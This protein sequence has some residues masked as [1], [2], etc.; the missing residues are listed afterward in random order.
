[1]G[2]KSSRIAP[3][4]AELKEQVV[5]LQKTV[6]ELQARNKPRDFVCSQ[7]NILA[8]YLGDNRQ[9]WFLYGI[10]CPPERREQIMTKF[11]QRG[12]DGRYVN[13]GWPKY[14][15]GI[16]TDAEMA[17]VE[18]IDEQHFAWSSRRPRVRDEILALDADLISLVELDD[19]EEY[20]KPEL[21]ARGY[22]SVFKKRPRDSSKDGCGIFFRTSAFELLASDSIEFVDRED[23]VTKKKQKDR[24]GLLAYLKH[25]SGRKV[26]FISTH[27]ARNP[28]DPKQTKSRAK[29]A[30]QLLQMLTDFAL[31]HDAMEVPV[32]LAGDMNTTSIKQIANI[33]RSVFELCE[34]P[35]HPFVF[36]AFAPR[37]LPTSV[38]TTRKM[39]IDYML[40]GRLDVIDLIPLPKLTYDAPIPNAEHPSDHVPL[41]FRF[42]FSKMSSHIATAARGYI[43]TLL[44]DANSAGA[45]PLNAAGL[46]DAFDFFDMEQ[47]GQCALRELEAALLDLQLMDKLPA[48]RSAIEAE[49]GHSLDEEASGGKALQFDE[50]SK[51]YRAAFL[52]ARAHFKKDMQDAFQYFDSDGS[53]QLEQKE[54]YSS[55]SAAC[56][57]HISEETF[58]GIFAKL[59]ANSDGTVT[60]DEFVDF[61]MNR[62]VT[63]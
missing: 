38:T 34:R 33:A 44:G 18:K 47:D 24:V 16:L 39:C 37:T 61:L 4:A 36:S 27:L 54:L 22:S 62:L 46:V 26:I 6:D 1:M 35:C 30:A 19:Y 59:D 51:A 10:D 52:R 5:R 25:S 55:F 9:P 49:I 56:P 23:P 14:V 28:E 17:T 40:V 41:T 53:G 63:K 11:Y 58:A 43:L 31:Q 29:Q 42:G 32:V 45:V 15:T 60:V 50:F 20:F 12:E 13:A 48:L 21:H 7:Y 3:E 2:A 8:G 57:F